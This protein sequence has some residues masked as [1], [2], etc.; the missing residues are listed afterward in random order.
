MLYGIHSYNPPQYLDTLWIN[1][2][3]P[4]STTAEKIYIVCII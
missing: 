1:K 2:T 3:S 4:G